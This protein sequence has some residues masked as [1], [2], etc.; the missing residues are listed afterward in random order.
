[1]PKSKLKQAFEQFKGVDHKLEKQKKLQKQAGKRK[2][3]KMED[4]EED[5]DAE[6]ATNGH[7][8]GHALEE[9][10]GAAEGVDADSEEEEGG[11]FVCSGRLH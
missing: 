10:D 8:N 6:K 5:D 2:R 9:E 4:V 11:A 1:M 3:S 7:A